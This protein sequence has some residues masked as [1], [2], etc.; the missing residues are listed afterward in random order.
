MVE[1]LLVGIG[2]A[3]GGMLRHLV[4][5]AVDL[6]T[7]ADWPWGTLVVNVSGACLIG[8]L[9]GFALPAAG[10]AKMPWIFL[11]IGLLGSYTTV[12]AF[13]LQTLTLWQAGR[14]RAALAYVAI[15]CALCLGAAATAFL[16]ASTMTGR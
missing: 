9:A 2:G 5:R 3:L 1:I 4:A 12:S 6:A 8:I 14:A 15:S 16:A 13:S 10:Q 11:A 7:R